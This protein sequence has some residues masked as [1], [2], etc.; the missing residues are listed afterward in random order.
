MT[1]NRERQRKLNHRWNA[2]SGNK[3]YDLTLIVIDVE[4]I[5]VEILATNQLGS[6][7]ILN[8]KQYTRHLSKEKNVVFTVYCTLHSHALLKSKI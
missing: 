5:I 2:E 4:G 1:Q 8:S 7:W 6:Q 3:N